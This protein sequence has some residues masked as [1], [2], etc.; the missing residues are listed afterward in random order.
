MRANMFIIT[1]QWKSV[2]HIRILIPQS[3]IVPMS[4]FDTMMP[5]VTRQDEIENQISK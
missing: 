1:F 2:N 5:R 3:G 4:T